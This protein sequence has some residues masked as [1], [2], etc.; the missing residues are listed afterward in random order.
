MSIKEEKYVKIMFN[1]IH[2]MSQV[3]AVELCVNLEPLAKVDTE[4][5]QQTTT[6][7]QFRS[8]ERRVGKEC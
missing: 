5:V 3:N 1:M 8:E 2:K 7:L 6:S 4:E